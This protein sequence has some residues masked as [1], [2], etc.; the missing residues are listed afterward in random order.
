MWQY[1]RRVD[2]K[3]QIVTFSLHTKPRR[4]GGRRKLTAEELAIGASAGPT[5]ET[6]SLS[7][8]FLAIP[9]VGS[10]H[11]NRENLG[12]LKYLCSP[13]DVN[14]GRVQAQ[15]LA[16]IR[17]GSSSSS[18]STSSASQSVQFISIDPEIHWI[19]EVFFLFHGIYIV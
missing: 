9:S 17:A 6:I 7:E 4:Q 8:E 19:R 18:S 14:G 15:A 5:L 3:A 10:S 16:A 1:S 13:A 11:K 2:G 12:Q